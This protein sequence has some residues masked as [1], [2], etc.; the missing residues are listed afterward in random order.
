MSILFPF[1]LCFHFY[2]EFF[3]SFY[4]SSHPW[5]PCSLPSEPSSEGRLLRLIQWLPCNLS[6]FPVSCTNAMWNAQSSK[7]ALPSFTWHCCL[8]FPLLPRTTIS[9]SKPPFWAFATVYYLWRYYLKQRTRLE[10]QLHHRLCD[11]VQVS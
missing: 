1:L 8:L 10:S 7:L 3:V 2:I 5:T 6:F 9:F 11:L 4:S